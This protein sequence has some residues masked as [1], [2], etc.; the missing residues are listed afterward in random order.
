MSTASILGPGSWRY[1]RVVVHAERAMRMARVGLNLFA[2]CT[3]VCKHIVPC[4]FVYLCVTLSVH[5]LTFENIA[6]QQVNENRLS[7]YDVE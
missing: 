3:R 4:T 6:E 5:L 7:L 2:T 1:R